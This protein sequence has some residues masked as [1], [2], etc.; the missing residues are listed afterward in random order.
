MAVRL[1]DI[2]TI[3][4]EDLPVSERLTFKLQWIYSDSSTDDEETL[5]AIDNDQ[6]IDD[7][8]LV[9]A[10]K[11]KLLTLLLIIFC[12]LNRYSDSLFIK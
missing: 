11:G 9:T 6:E 8:V 5:D 3:L 4:T 2:S 12:V 10:E 1:A 7:D